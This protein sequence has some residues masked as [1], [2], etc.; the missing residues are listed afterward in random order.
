MNHKSG[1]LA[2]TLV[3]VLGG[4]SWFGGP[5]VE[6]PAA[7]VEFKPAAEVTKVWSAD[8]GKGPDRRFLRLAPVRNGDTLYVVDVTGSARALAQAEGRLCT[9]PSAHVQARGAPGDARC[10]PHRPTAPHARRWHALHTPQLRTHALLPLAHHHLIL[11][12][13]R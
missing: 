8:I 11:G 7:L 10:R 3:L 6:Q 1:S 12:V 5:E 13:Q 4:C 9:V 2:L